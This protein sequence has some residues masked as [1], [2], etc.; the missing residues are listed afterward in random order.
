MVDVFFLQFDS[1]ASILFREVSRNESFESFRTSLLGCMWSVW[2][3]YSPEDSIKSICDRLNIKI[4]IST[5]TGQRVFK[6]SKTSPIHS[7]SIVYNPQNG[8]FRKKDDENCMNDSS[9]SSMSPSGTHNKP[10]EKGHNRLELMDNS[11]NRL[12]FPADA[13][14]QL[15]RLKSKDSPHIV[16]INEVLKDRGKVHVT[17]DAIRRPLSRVLADEENKNLQY[18]LRIARDVASGLRD[19]HCVGFFH[20][21][22]HPSNINYANGC[23]QLSLGKLTDSKLSSQET[24]KPSYGRTHEKNATPFQK[25]VWACACL[26]VE[27]STGLK[28]NRFSNEEELMDKV[29]ANGNAA[30]LGDQ[31]LQLISDMLSI[32]TRSHPTVEVVLTR[33]KDISQSIRDPWSDRFSLVFRFSPLLNS[34]VEYTYYMSCAN[35]YLAQK[36]P[37][38]GDTVLTFLFQMSHDLSLLYKGTCQ[39]VN[40]MRIAGSE[41][42]VN[43]IIGVVNGYISEAFPVWCNA[44]RT[45]CRQKKIVSDIYKAATRSG[46][47]C[48]RGLHEFL[49]IFDSNSQMRGMTFETVSYL[50]VSMSYVVFQKIK[51]IKDY[52]VLADNFLKLLEKNVNSLRKAD[53][54]VSCLESLRT[55]ANFTWY[56]KELSAGCS[57][58]AS[59]FH[60]TLTTQSLHATLS[61][62]DI[63]IRLSDIERVK[64]SKDYGDH[65]SYK[66][67]IRN[68]SPLR[69]SMSIEDGKEL[70]QRLLSLSIPV[71]GRRVVSP[72]DAMTFKESDFSRIE[73]L[74]EQPRSTVFVART[75][76]R[77]TEV[78][79]KVAN[80]VA[81]TFKE[82]ENLKMAFSNAPHIRIVRPL[83]IAYLEQG[84]LGLVTEF[85]K[86]GSLERAMRPTCSNCM[87]H[88]PDEKR[89]PRLLPSTAGRF[90]CLR[91]EKPFCKHCVSKCFGESHV[92]VPIDMCY[93]FSSLT[94][95]CK[96]MFDRN[97]KKKVLAVLR[98]VA[99]AMHHLHSR[100]MVHRDIKSS[101]IMLNENMEGYLSD[102]EF[103]RTV[104]ADGTSQT[105]LGTPGWKAPEVGRGKYTEKCDVWS[106]GVLVSEIVLGFV[107]VEAC[108]D[109]LFTCNLMSDAVFKC[110]T[111]NK[112][113]C[114]SHVGNKCSEGNKNHTIALTKLRH[115]SSYLPTRSRPCAIC[116]E[117]IPEPGS[118][119]GNIIYLEVGCYCAESQKPICEKCH[120][121]LGCNCKH[122]S[123]NDLET[124]LLEISNGCFKEVDSERP[125]FEEILSSIDDAMK[126][127]NNHDDDVMAV[128]A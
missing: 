95:K 97:D 96:P 12:S 90:W 62:A 91:C 44:L 17:F 127:R 64:V 47:K 123:W 56:H 28:R 36:Q 98:N 119:S 50:P 120:K 35:E 61:G 29:R 48:E 58:C 57:S 106:F 38:E 13:Y 87:A 54:D 43:Q 70:Q 42:N 11:H 1:L 72:I 20:G 121:D 19:L 34:L 84:Q 22:V 68:R 108:D 89:R 55:P 32:G 59:S 10:F 18:V 94:E 80:S 115:R 67:C 46:N 21:E 24:Q 111:C 109:C 27:I 60:V 5:N 14:D 9:V 126:P 110:S 113:L 116:V 118:I 104:D 105:N 51:E 16:P 83:G 2:N 33:L 23:A 99:E 52:P 39:C 74:C 76:M 69:I 112:R 77:P 114:R 37:P 31:M 26:L 81:V 65:V 86:G 40:A 88:D 107:P 85:M 7:C 3:P 15:R 128:D 30:Y 103:A 122:Q 71:R 93:N 49:R 82:L 79:I 78:A 92:L 117:R 25:D 75:G 100:K 101:N 6:P 66:F 124:S 125:S 8:H 45:S 4:C 53:Q 102:L 73:V 41:R 63:E